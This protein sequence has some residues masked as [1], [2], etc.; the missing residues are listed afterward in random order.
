MGVLV[1]A[2]AAAWGRRGGP[3]RGRGT[4]RG[5]TSRPRYEQ[6]RIEREARVCCAP[7]AEELGFRFSTAR[8]GRMWMD[9]RVV[10]SLWYDAIQAP[11]SAWQHDMY[12]DVAAGGG[13]G[14]GGGGRVSAIET[15]TKL[16][17]SNLDFGVSTED[18]KVYNNRVE[19]VASE[20]L[21][22]EESR[23]LVAYVISLS[24]SPDLA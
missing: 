10:F 8:R 12:S 24:Y 9:G 3:S 18:I 16:Y 14:S 17:I 1:V 5:P 4:G 21:A 20:Q 11:E 19:L 22:L 2:A 6:Q 23:Y 13:G 7:S 15:G